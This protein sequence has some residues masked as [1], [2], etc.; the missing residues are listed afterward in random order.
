M[1]SMQTARTAPYGT[2]PS[3]GNRSRTARTLRTQQHSLPVASA[4]SITGL[5]QNTLAVIVDLS[6]SSPGLT[7]G[8]SWQPAGDP[9]ATVAI[10]VGAGLALLGSYA[11]YVQ[12][13]RGSS[14]ARPTHQIV[15]RR[16]SR[17]ECHSVP[18]VVSTAVCSCPSSAVACTI[19]P[20]WRVPT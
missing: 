11:V 20:S 14:G 19:N 1:I 8:E 6:T 5:L 16:L 15:E 10:T 13:D 2:L 7:V 17:I 9:S 18:C 12:Q 4:E 3:R